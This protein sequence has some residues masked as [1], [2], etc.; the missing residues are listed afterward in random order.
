MTD[1]RTFV[2]VGASLTGAKAAETLRGEGFAGRIVLIGEET[3]RPYERLPLS[4]GHLLGTQ[5][6][7][8]AFVHDAE[9]YPSH[10]IDL[11][12]G[13]RVTDLD[14]KAHTITLDDV[15]PM[16]YDKLALA[17]GSRVRRLDLPGSDNLGIRYLRTITESDAILSDLREGANV[18]VV[19]AGW[20]GLE[21][22]AAARTHGGNVNLVLRGQLP[23]VGVLGKELGAIYAELHR[24]RGITFHTDAQVR[25]FR[26]SGGHVTHAV[27]DNGTELP[28]DLV[29]MGVGITPAIE[30]AQ[31]AG[32]E[33]DNGVVTD[34]SLRTSD[35][36]IYAAGDIA[37][38]F[39]PLVGHRIRVEHWANALNGG[40][41]LAKAMLGLDMVYDRVPY[42]YSDQYL[43]EPSISMEYAGYVGPDGYD[44]VVIRGDA[45]I[46]PDANPEF[47]AFWVSG[48]KVLA[49]LNANIWDVQDQI[50][51]L[52][53]AGYAGTSVDLAKL[54]DPD[55]PLDDLL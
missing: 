33:I 17:T 53:R 12:L 6:R 34:Q 42:F 40:K 4:K 48:G 7:D 38:S 2:I 21:V 39:N 15:E 5:A 43:G 25:E 16:R 26:G 37:S 30:L 55:V 36:D 22:A 31:T 10:D 3:D 9:W 23:L 46:R 49:G 32:L 50:Q 41:A 14:A 24:T 19:G 35:P 29:V 54:A 44:Q 45:T 8:K 47:L 11:V 28:A 51:A 27:L 18:V 20:I 52:V 13:V 1:E